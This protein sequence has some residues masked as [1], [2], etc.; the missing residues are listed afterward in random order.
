MR[1]EKRN[2]Q[3]YRYLGII[4]LMLFVVLEM[5]VM[6]HSNWVNSLDNTAFAMVKDPNAFLINFFNI[7][8]K[9]SSPAV[10]MILIVILDLIVWF[11]QKQHL[12][13][14]WLAVMQ[15]PIIGISW[16]VKQTVRRP[17][18]NFKIIPDHGFGFPSGHTLCITIL[19]IS[20]L[21]VI[22]TK[23]SNSRV[24]VVLII[25]G[26]V[27]IALVGISRFLLRDHYITDVIGSLLLA[28]GY[29]SVMYSIRSAVENFL[30]RYLD[31]LNIG[32]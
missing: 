8:A 28:T 16:I 5:G 25:L 29:W 26:V 6:G 23:I 32:G 17:R 2:S 1:I 19:I 3:I 20:L 21:L 13:A 12:L 24:K 4:L 27:W 15:I 14:T 31:K 9:I 30:Q 18:P 10:D 11:Y 7:V 22:F